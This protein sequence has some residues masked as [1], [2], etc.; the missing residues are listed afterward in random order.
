MATPEQKQSRINAAHKLNSVLASIGDIKDDASRNALTHD[1]IADAVSDICTNGAGKNHF[2]QAQ[3]ECLTEIGFHIAYVMDPRNRPPRS[4]RARFSRDF[5][6]ATTLQR[7]ALVGQ[8]IAIAVGC[9]TIVG[10]AAA[11]ATW[12]Y[13]A[14]FTSS[15]P[16]A[17]DTTTLD[18]AL[19][20]PNSDGEVPP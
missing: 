12:G 20:P 11:A 14:L 2:T 18:P 17:S 5:A 15:M 16:A 3:I 9:I 4:F 10:G 13:R 6:D 8:L 19:L 1:Q 7:V